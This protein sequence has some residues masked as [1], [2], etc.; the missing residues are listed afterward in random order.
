M[1]KYLIH[2]KERS[3]KDLPPFLCVMVKHPDI[4]TPFP[5]SVFIDFR[6]VSSIILMRS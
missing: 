5:Q 2:Y 4:P 1:G 6:F 3:I